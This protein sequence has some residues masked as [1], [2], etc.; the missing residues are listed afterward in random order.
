MILAWLIFTGV[1]IT[2]AR[3]YKSVWADKTFLKLKVWFQVGIWDTTYV[4]CTILFLLTCKEGHKV[5]Y[6]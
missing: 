3:Y 4:L 6:T 5:N 2:T 1:G